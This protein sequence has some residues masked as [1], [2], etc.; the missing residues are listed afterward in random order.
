MQSHLGSVVECLA[1]IAW[2][3]SKFFR[4]FASH[5]H[6][7]EWPRPSHDKSILLATCF[8]IVGILSLTYP[9]MFLQYFFNKRN[10]QS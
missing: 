2:L 10:G 9:F 6:G 4:T 8:I 7:H 5:A 3:G 1:G